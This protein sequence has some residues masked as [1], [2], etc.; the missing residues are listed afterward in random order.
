MATKLFTLSANIP[1]RSS[2][3]H[4]LVGDITSAFDKVTEKLTS[5]NISIISENEELKELITTVKEEIL[6]SVSDVQT[7]AEDAKEQSAKNANDIVLLQN[8]MQK[9]QRHCNVLEEEN[10][11]LKSKSEQIE[12]YS[13]RDNLVIH[14][15]PDN[16]NETN[17][18][19]ISAAR[20]F[21][22][23]QLEL[24]HNTVENIRFVRCHRMGMMVNITSHPRPIIMRFYHYDMRELVWRAC[25]KLKGKKPYSMSEDFPQG[26]A[27]RRRLLYIIYREAIRS[28]DYQTVK[29]NR[30]VLTINNNRYTVDN[31]HTLPKKINPATLSYKT[32]QESYVVGG[33]FSEYNKLSNWSK[34]DF[35]FKDHDYISIEQGWQHRKALLAGD[36]I[37]AHKIMCSTKPK[38]AKEL[39]R[40]VKMTSVNRNKWDAGR[41]DLMLAMVRAKVSQ[42]RD[43]K[44][45]LLDTGSKRIG[46]SGV[47][48][49]F[50]TIGLK[51]TDNLV[52]DNKKWKTGNLMGKV[53]ERVRSEIQ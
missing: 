22:K 30:D 40:N 17:E 21:M 50:Y 24:D 23:Q 47:N 6:N 3:A 53:Y 52:L 27:E 12:L 37:S 14:G 7:T 44:S 46:E 5:I 51:L 34:S 32:N 8:Q 15:V 41:E 11:S 42:N 31:L 33:I 45:A 43:V 49:Q 20:L 36:Q 9:L 29:L 18:Q 35:T 13:R 39:G 28:N 16:K 26:M 10:V 48:D 19:C 25:P 1:D 38:S 2:W 4:H